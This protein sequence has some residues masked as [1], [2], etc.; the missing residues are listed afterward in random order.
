MRV[1]GNDGPWTTHVYGSY[2]AQT[3]VIL[4]NEAAEQPTQNCQPFQQ[5]VT[6]PI[7]PGKSI[8]RSKKLSRFVHQG[9]MLTGE[10]WFFHLKSWFFVV[11]WV[12]LQIGGLP[13]MSFFN[14]GMILKIYLNN[15]TDLGSTY[16]GTMLLFERGSKPR[17]VD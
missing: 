1:V 6:S 5:D 9:P 2:E 16:F 11:G 10:W 13:K 17:L 4:P 12:C 7:S 8:L 14:M 3:Y 15:G